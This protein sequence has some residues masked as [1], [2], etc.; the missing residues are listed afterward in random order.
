MPEWIRKKNTSGVRRLV[1]YVNSDSDPE[2]VQ[3]LDSIPYGDSGKYVRAALRFYIER[4]LNPG[5]NSDPKARRRKIAKSIPDSESRISEARTISPRKIDPDPD[6]DPD[7]AFEPAPDPKIP[8]TP[9]SFFEKKA[10]DSRSF[11][12]IKSNPVKS[13]DT[14]PVSRVETDSENTAN[15]TD[16]DSETLKALTLF[17]NQ[18]GD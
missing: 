1:T 2:I 3:W 16:F 11:Y 12:E 8:L 17:N 5:I 18:F 15:L 13:V 6:P 4:G 14:P 9:S 7:P 10:S